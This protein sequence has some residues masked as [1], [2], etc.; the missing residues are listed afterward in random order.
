MQ[1]ADGQYAIDSREKRNLGQ[2]VEVVQDHLD[3]DVDPLHDEVG[4]ANDGGSQVGSNS[5]DHP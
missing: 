1:K 2:I 3:E 4:V 5:A